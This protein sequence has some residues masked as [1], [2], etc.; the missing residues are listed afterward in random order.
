MPETLSVSETIA[1]RADP[2]AFQDRLLRPMPRGPSEAAAAG[3]AFHDW[4]E[5]RLGQQELFIPDVSGGF[6]DPSDLEALVSGDFSPIL[7]EMFAKTEFA[8]RTP[9]AVEHPFTIHVNGLTI[10]GKIDAVF[11]APD[12]GGRLR[13]GREST[14]QT[15]YQVVDWKTGATGRSDPNQL[16]LYRYAWAEY[17]SVP[18]EHVDAA[19]VYVA[20]GEVHW[21]RDLPEPAELLS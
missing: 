17:A 7:I 1:W 15:R 16:A 9:A 19:F 3:T 18:I 11:M 12:P 2:K 4:V 10:T 5:R 14:E 13:E 6:V 8:D 21:Y 20:S